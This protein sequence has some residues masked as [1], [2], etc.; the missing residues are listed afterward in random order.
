[1]E[2]SLTW[3]SGVTAT[4]LSKPSDW[5]Q[6]V[7]LGINNANKIVGNYFQTYNP[8][9]DSEQRASLWDGGTLVLLNN[10]VPGGSGWTLNSA[11]R[12]NGLNQIVGYG[13][14]GGQFHAFRLKP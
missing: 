9:D 11:E 3:R 2:S 1:L 8:T 7:A 4:L 5:N 12:I 14:F 6:S 13:S 10:F